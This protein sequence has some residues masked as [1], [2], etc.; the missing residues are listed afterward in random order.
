[1]T[2]FF[3]SS[4]RP[5]RVSLIAPSGAVD[6]DRYAITLQRLGQ[7]GVDVVEGDHVL[8][9][10]YYLAGTATQRVEDLHAAY[11]REDIDAVWCLRGGYG[12]DH[13][14][15]LIDW[16]RIACH[17]QRPLIGYSDITVLLEAFYRHGIAALHAPVATELAL[18]T[19]WPPETADER[20]Q[21]L[22]SLATQCS[23]ACGHMPTKHYAGPHTP[24][25]GELRGGNLVT[26]AALCGTPGALVLERPT[27]LM[28]EEVGEAD[29]RIERC[30]HQLL[31]SIDTR[32]LTGVCLGS[33]TRQG[34]P[35]ESSHA[36]LAE[37]L[38]PLDI[39]LHYHLPFG[40][41]PINHAW[42]YGVTATLSDTGVHWQR[43]GPLITCV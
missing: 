22:C 17:P 30:F 11:E 23:E 9:R 5:L 29:Y 20:W 7:L 21:S 8:Q 28:L 33:F 19:P 10:H 42:P 32:W 12:A 43:S 13:L 6:A 24:A 36:I 35:T 4:S 25:T 1:M 18:V 41:H 37:W 3:P 40:H 16:T 38:A 26:L 14:L 34:K 15:P 31:T 27:L 39:P 2:R